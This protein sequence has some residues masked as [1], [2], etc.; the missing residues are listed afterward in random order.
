MSLTLSRF[1]P[2]SNLGNFNTEYTGHMCYCPMHLDLSAPKASMASW[3]ATGKPLRPSGSVDLV[4]F[5]DGTTT[6][7]CTNCGMGSVDLAIAADDREPAANQAVM[8]TVTRDNIETAGIF[9]DYKDTFRGAVSVQMSVM[10][11]EESS[12]HY[13]KEARCL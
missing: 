8:W 1:P 13:W 9:E 3:I 2:N 10:D 6:A 5:Q 7:L 4:T 11:P 12:I